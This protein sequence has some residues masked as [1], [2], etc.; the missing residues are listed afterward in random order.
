M[1]NKFS[2]DAVEVCF[3][4]SQFLRGTIGA[5]GTAVPLLVPGLRIFTSSA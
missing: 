3:S 4:A 1:I 5:A 2:V